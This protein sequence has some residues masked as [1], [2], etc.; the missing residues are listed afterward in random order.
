MAGSVIRILPEDVANKI[1]AGEVVERPASVVKELLENSLD[2]GARRIR[3]TIVAGG[4]RL[5]SVSDDGCGMGREDALMAPQRQ[6]TSKLRTADDLADIETM[7]FRGEAL[8][9]IASVSRF[10]LVTRRESD[11][12]ATKVEINGGVLS[13]VSECGAPPGTCIEVRDLFYN[14]PARRAFLR[15]YATEQAHVRAQFIVHA[16]AW[17]HVAMELVCDGDQTN[18]LPPAADRRER[19]EALFG[20]GWLDRFFAVE[21]REGDLHVYGWAGM[22]DNTRGDTAGQ[23]VFVNGRPATAP[24][25]QAAIRESYPRL[26]PGR[27]PVVFL[28]VDLPGSQVDVNVHPAKRE[29]RF[30]ASGAV[31]DAVLAALA[32]ALRGSAPDLNTATSNSPGAANYPGATSS[33]QWGAPAA[34]WPSPT[35][36]ASSSPHGG[37]ENAGHGGLGGFA[38]LPPPLPPLAPPPVQTVFAPVDD[39]TFAPHPATFPSRSAPDATMSPAESESAAS[40]P[41]AQGFGAP[42]GRSPETGVRFRFVGMLHSG[43]ALVEPQ[44]G[45]LA[46]VDPAAARERVAYERLLRSPAWA[47]E[48]S[49]GLLLPQTVKLQP[50]DAGRV[51][52][53]L[54]ILSQMGFEVE[55]FGGDTFVV[56][57]LPDAISGVS[58]RE[59]LEET[60]RA[61]AEAG[62][63]KGRERWREERLA[64]VAARIAGRSR[65]PVDPRETAALILELAACSMPYATPSGRP[66]M[67]HFPLGDI[68]RRL[69]RS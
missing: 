65:R 52:E 67:V 22:P 4:R 42:E 41:M 20:A 45:G 12:S 2:A 6:A 10:T 7:G 68:E 21:R 57:A 3:V 60:A 55:D 66:T 40:K 9:S 25:L 56:R 36:P 61:F 50:V 54:P 17:P 1:A 39:R 62:P 43:Y 37:G 64:S 59:M 58:A 46:V 35:T 30:R 29:V 14:V 23:F 63:R 24:V 13:D 34:Q 47:E 33:S 18:R 48:Q 69:G 28:F 53:L 26:Q 5:I 19:I 8:P 44:G 51:R 49:Q 11:T 27:R 16:I 38:P 32:T 15:A 31:R